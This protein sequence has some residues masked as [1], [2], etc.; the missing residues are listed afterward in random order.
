M[1]ENITFSIISKIVP[2]KSVKVWGVFVLCLIFSAIGV[3]LSFLILGTTIQ[4]YRLW[5]V[6][7][8]IAVTMLGI[9]YGAKYASPESRESFTPVDFIQYLTQGFLWPS[10]WPALA[11]F[12][13]VGKIEPPP[14]AVLHFIETIKFSLFA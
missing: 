8:V 14:E 5:G 10:T 1:P 2:Q 7:F 13:G 4:G 12:L 3:G 11:E 6:G 9:N